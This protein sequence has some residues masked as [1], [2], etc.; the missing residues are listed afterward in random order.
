[1]LLAVAGYPWPMHA[2][3]DLV[4]IPILFATVF[5]S[6]WLGLRVG[7]AHRRRKVA[8]QEHLGTIQGAIL[9]LLGL[10]LG[11]SF[12]GAM[13]RFID[14]Q[15]ALAVEANAI[16]TAYERVELL[17]NAEGVRE[18]LRAYTALR[19]ELFHED[20]EAPAAAITERLL[21]RHEAAR[22][23]L[24]DV[25]RQ[26]SQ[27]ATLVI[28]GLEAVGDE[29]ARRTAFDRRH[30]P[31]EMILVLILSSCL[32]I[33]TIG[34]GIGLTERQRLG[35]ALTLAALIAITLF[36]TIDFDRPRRGFIALD[37][38]PLEN[39]ARTMSRK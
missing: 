5:A 7:Q 4:I 38:T 6:L 39:A 14:R 13:N 1:M 23:A 28:P 37:G 29:F 35:P 30:L 31:S 12:S 25:V 27:F 18:H 16:E 8:E 17:P 9:G 20:R 32:S 34:Y 10:I 19:L 11:F 15:D 36:V 22:A 24:F 21:A 33:G 26:S 2:L 3:P